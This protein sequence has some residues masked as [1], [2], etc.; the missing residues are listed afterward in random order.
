MVDEIEM[1]MR[2]G[3][4]AFQVSADGDDYSATSPTY[5]M[6]EAA[7]LQ[8]DGFKVMLSASDPSL[9]NQ[10]LAD[11]Y[12]AF[13]AHPNVLRHSNGALVVS[14]YAPDQDEGSGYRISPSRWTAIFA[15]IGEPVFFLPSLGMPDSQ[16]LIDYGAVAHGLSTWRGNKVGDF[17]EGN[18][19]D[20]T[21]DYCT[22]NGKEFMSQVMPQDVRPPTFGYAESRGSRSWQDGWDFAI[23]RT[24]RYMMIGTWNDYRESHHIEPSINVGH[25]W[26]DIA[27]YYISWLKGGSEPTIVRDVLYYFYRLERTDAVGTGTAQDGNRFELA[28]GSDGPFEEIEL[29]AFL[30]ASGRLH[31]LDDGVEVS[32]QDVSAGIQ[33][34]RTTW[35]QGV[36]SFKLSRSAVDIVT[37]TGNWTTRTTSDYQDLLYHSGCSTRTPNAMP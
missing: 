24:G 32:A 31:I 3:I 13:K 30:T 36:P 20:L 2:A 34:L 8:G 16:T 12:N 11:F 4:D 1:A 33:R 28:A 19:L 35:F 5:R 27:R 25:S 23:T 18:G 37:L 26:I 6:L 10:E 17:S 15:L 7:R 29:L 9:T 22:A 14:T 21:A